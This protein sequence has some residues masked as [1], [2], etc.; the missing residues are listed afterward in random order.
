MATPLEEI[1]EYV[2]RNRKIEPYTENERKQL[3]MQLAQQQIRQQRNNQRAFALMLEKAA[4]SQRTTGGTDGL[5]KDKKAVQEPVK[6]KRVGQFDLDVIQELILNDI[7]W[8]QPSNRQT[9]KMGRK[10]KTMDLDIDSLI[11]PPS[12][13]NDSPETYA[14]LLEAQEMGM[15]RGERADDISAQLGKEGIIATFKKYSD[16]NDLMTNWDFVRM[17]IDDVQ[18]ICLNLKFAHNRVRPSTLAQHLGVVLPTHDDSAWSS[19]PS[20]PSFHSTVGRVIASVISGAYIGHRERLMRIGDTIGMNRIIGGYHFLTDHQAGQSLGDQ[21]VL[22]ITQN[23]SINPVYE[24]EETIDSRTAEAVSVN[25]MDALEHR[26]RMMEVNKEEG[27][28]AHYAEGIQAAMA[29]HARETAHMTDV[30]KARFDDYTEFGSDAPLNAEGRKAAEQDKKNRKKD[31]DNAIS[32]FTRVTRSNGYTEYEHSFL[33]NFALSEVGG[34]KLENGNWVSDGETYPTAEHAYQASKFKDEKHRAN[35]RNATNDRTG[36]PDPG[37]AKRIAGKLLSNNRNL[38]YMQEKGPTEVRLM[39]NVLVDKF[40]SNAGLAKQLADTGT[41]PLIEGNPWGDKFWGVSGGKGKNTLGELLYRVRQDLNENPPTKSEITRKSTTGTTPHSLGLGGNAPEK[42]FEYKNKKQK[43]ENSEKIKRDDA[44][45]GTQL[46]L[47]GVEQP[48]PKRHI[49]VFGSNLEGVHGAG[50]AETAKKKHGAV[51]GVGFGISGNTLG[52]PTKKTPSKRER[53][54]SLDELE[55]NIAEAVGFMEAHPE[56]VFHV[57][58]IGTNLAGYKPE[59]VADSFAKAMLLEYDSDDEEF[60]G[61]HRRLVDGTIMFGEKLTPLIRDRI[62]NENGKFDSLHTYGGMVLG[63]FEELTPD[64]V[65]NAFTYDQATFDSFPH[66]S[67]DGE[68]IPN[69]YTADLKNRLLITGGRDN[70]DY[71]VIYEA[72]KANNPDVVIHGGAKGADRNAEIAAVTLGIPTEV[73]PPDW[74]GQGKSA[75]FKRNS[76]M[77]EDGKPTSVIAFRGGNGTADM[78]KKAGKAGF[79]VEKPQD[80]TY[81]RDMPS[82]YAKPSADDKPN[83]P[84]G[85]KTPPLPPQPSDTTREGTYSTVPSDDW[86]RKDEDDSVPPTKNEPVEESKTPNADKYNRGVRRLEE[87]ISTLEDA[88]AETGGKKLTKVNPKTG[89]EEDVN[90]RAA[91]DLEDLKGELSTMQAAGAPP[92]AEAPVEGTP[93]PKSTP[94]EGELTAWQRA[95]SPRPENPDVDQSKTPLERRQELLPPTSKEEEEARRKS[96]AELQ[97]ETGDVEIEFVTPSDLI[98]IVGENGQPYEN[99]KGYLGITNDSEIDSA[100]GGDPREFDPGKGVERLENWLKSIPSGSLVS[101]RLLAPFYYKYGLPENKDNQYDLSEFLDKF[102]RVE[103]AGKTATS[104]EGFLSQFSAFESENGTDNLLELFD[105][106]KDFSPALADNY[107]LRSDESEG[108][109][110]ATVGEFMRRD[111]SRES[112]PAD[113]EREAEEEAEAKADEAE[114]RVLSGAEGADED[115]GE[116]ESDNPGYMS[117]EGFKTYL[118]LYNGW[119]KASVE[120]RIIVSKKWRERRQPLLD[121]FT[122]DRLAKFLNDAGLT[123][124]DP[125]TSSPI[126]PELGD[127]GEA[128]DE[129]V[130]QNKNGKRANFDIEYVALY[131]GLGLRKYRQGDLMDMMMTP[132]AL[133]DLIDNPRKH[134]NV[135]ANWINPVLQEK[136][137]ELKAFRDKLIDSDRAMWNSLTGTDNSNPKFKNRGAEFFKQALLHHEGPFAAMSRVF[138]STGNLRDRFNPYTQ[139]KTSDELKT[140]AQEVQDALLNRMPY[141]GIGEPSETLDM[142][143]EQQQRYMVDMLESITSRKNKSKYAGSSPNS[144]LDNTDFRTLAASLRDKFNRLRTDIMDKGK[145][146][147]DGRGSPEAMD[148]AFRGLHKLAN[149]DL[150]ALFHTL[151]LNNVSSPRKME[152]FDFSDIPAPYQLFPDKRAAADF[153][154]SFQS[155]P[156]SAQQA[157]AKNITSG[158]VIDTDKFMQSVRNKHSDELEGQRFEERRRHAETEGARHGVYVVPDEPEEY[159]TGGG[160]LGTER[161]T[162]TEADRAAD[163]DARIMD[164]LQENV[165]ALTELV[166]GVEDGTLDVPGDRYENAKTDLTFAKAELEE[167][168]KKSG[169]SEE[170]KRVKT[171]T[172]TLD[173]ELIMAL[174]NAAKELGDISA[175]AQGVPVFTYEQDDSIVMSA[176]G[177]FNAKFEEVQTRGRSG[178]TATIDRLSASERDKFISELQ[179]TLDADQMPNFIGV[180]EMGAAEPNETADEEGRPIKTTGE[181]PQGQIVGI[182]VVG[183]PLPRGSVKSRSYNRQHHASLMSHILN[184]TTTTDQDSAHWDRFKAYTAKRD[185]LTDTGLAADRRKAVSQGV[186]NT[187]AGHPI[188]KEEGFDAMKGG[189]IKI[190]EALHTDEGYVVG[191]K[192]HRME[193]FLKQ[194]VAGEDGKQKLKYVQEGTTSPETQVMNGY[195]NQEHKTLTDQYNREDGG[196][197]QTEA[198]LPNDLQ[199]QAQ[200]SGSKPI[201]E[202]TAIG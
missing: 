42:K 170:K 153:G 17:V 86:P 163:K 185:G 39:S 162:G 156:Y 175:A 88:I 143:G 191:D 87:Q 166:N 40:R 176:A 115:E 67:D 3:I 57:A 187:I 158:N 196:A 103:M 194:M 110:Y 94:T 111:E 132:G 181:R 199:P 112:S 69:T 58:D 161:E 38:A 68:Y 101:G 12:P 150:R 144:L 83:L 26:H 128:Y 5:G 79:E 104:S 155:A 193:D 192:A 168:A 82:D 145:A 95:G 148:K 147:P 137:Y 71:K 15:L 152:E 45:A 6:A 129:W 177:K 165:I 90:A 34:W 190:L 178:L 180:H 157:I 16:D 56:M 62:L 93:A 48:K 134:I 136:I 35:I 113:L 138:K 124:G 140:D 64:D 63:D 44:D 66:V 65:W 100:S 202:D 51:D 73:Y 105:F 11:L 97:E 8:G 172:H 159:E 182:N 160:D 78:V 173:D 74:D 76:Q 133:D 200:P 70:E 18:T 37:K 141:E 122:E 164:R 2:D 169:Q 183:T 41:V 201:T 77:L 130:A 27:S 81:N 151:Q 123:S 121:G 179:D 72:I 53:Q 127:D 28:E 84:E 55:D 107:R 80:Q 126:E 195:L 9:K 47:P 60:A 171:F 106:L 114:R 75:A 49:F 61:F 14:E 31:E 22:K 109:T 120:E 23:L 116:D 7:Q 167:F 186:A 43:S 188:S 142:T 59:E 19:S 1:H 99:S 89:E 119:S 174:N 98:P 189:I 197:D 54:F 139:P 30:M 29:T 33:S 117:G 198:S 25:F 92:E 108:G 52:V 50:A 102:I 154:A 125:K 21:L 32:K 131:H 118:D 24:K 20:Y 10:I 149:A 36:K 146:D 96:A 135:G 184:N 4:P 91:Q 85:G 46:G 13:D